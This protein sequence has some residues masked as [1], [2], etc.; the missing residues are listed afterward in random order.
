MNVMIESITGASNN[1][2]A[3]SD[4]DS[5]TDECKNSQQR[6]PQFLPAGSPHWLQLG[7]AF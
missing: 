4:Q 2:N 1:T 3:D 6:P 5:D 7:L